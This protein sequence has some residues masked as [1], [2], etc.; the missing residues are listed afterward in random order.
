[1]FKRTWDKV[2]M[3]LWLLTQ[4]SDCG[5][6]VLLWRFDRGDADHK[7]AMSWRPPSLSTR[8]SVSTGWRSSLPGNGDSMKGKLY[9]V[10]P[11]NLHEGPG[12]S[13]S[14]HVMSKDSLDLSS[15][16]IL[17]SMHGKMRERVKDRK[18]EGTGGA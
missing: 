9:V 10:S 18:G 1:M 16:N 12:T 4:V 15:P 11:L 6:D 17:E 5:V 13:N 14:V 8:K 3:A 2:I 7:L